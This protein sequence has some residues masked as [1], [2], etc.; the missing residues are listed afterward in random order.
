MTRGE[1]A[2]AHT[3]NRTLYYGMAPVIVV[4]MPSTRSK[5]E[6]C[7]VRSA[8]NEKGRLRRASFEELTAIPKKEEAA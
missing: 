1:L 6:V 3:Y 7:V 2:I 4:Q 8:L 5:S